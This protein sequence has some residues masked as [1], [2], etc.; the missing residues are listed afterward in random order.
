MI[1]DEEKNLSQILNRNELLCS[2]PTLVYFKKFWSFVGTFKVNVR[3]IL[4]EFNANF[5]YAT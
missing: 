2:K 5:R 4:G 1:F 3:A